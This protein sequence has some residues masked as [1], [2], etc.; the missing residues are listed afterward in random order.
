VAVPPIAVNGRFL[1]MTSTGVQ[2][3]AREILSRLGGR[4][5]GRVRVVVP[6]D[7]ILAADD[8]ELREIGASS[9]WHGVRGHAWEQF[10]LPRIVRRTRAAV[11]WSPC[12]W[13]PVVVRRQVPVIHDIAPLIQP[14]YFTTAYRGIARLLT[15][16][17][18]RHAVTVTTPSSR[19][20]AELLERFSLPPDRVLVVPPGV[21]APF[22]SVP[23]EPDRRPG[24]Y[25]LHVGA[26]DSRKN[27]DFLLELWPEV[28]AR[29]GLELHV[30]QRRLVIASRRQA[31]EDR[32]A[33][34]VVHVEPT[35]EE[36]AGLY[37]GA[38]CLLWPSHYEGYG[39]P[40]LETM[41]TGTPFLA[42]DVG[43]AA[44]LA[45]DP[46]QQIL[47]LE[48]DAWIRRIEEWSR[49]GVARLGE[50]SAE[51]ARARTWEAAAEQ[52][53]VLLEQ[54]AGPA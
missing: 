24:R 27:V 54:L 41:A 3:Y 39:F 44:E 43:A 11:L 9:R 34:V 1:T 14:E 33:G 2:R 12:N 52:T 23:L 4:L 53:A 36:L 51:R 7:R 25:C 45:V 46:A 18:V 15:G 17:L 6:P 20:R 30:T 5:E 26:H 38:L 49:G 8:P 50:E 21:G 48:R 19:V 28:H 47:P 22:T 29:T 40:L 35:D 37:A 13:G 16:P 32:S 31:L 42:A 10:V